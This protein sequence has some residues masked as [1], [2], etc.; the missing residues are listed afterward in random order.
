MSLFILGSFT[1]RDYSLEAKILDLEEENLG[2]WISHL[3]SKS[4]SPHL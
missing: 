2:S 4:P 1:L 3:T